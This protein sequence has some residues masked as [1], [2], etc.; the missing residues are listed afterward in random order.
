MCYKLQHG[1]CSFGIQANFHLGLPITWCS[2]KMSFSRT[3]HKAEFASPEP[4]LLG[5]FMSYAGCFHPYHNP[6]F[7]AHLN[8]SFMYIYAKASY[9][10]YW[11]AS[12]SEFSLSWKHIERTTG[13]QWKWVIRAFSSFFCSD[14]L[15]R[16]HISQ[17]N[18]ADWKKLSWNRG[19]SVLG[20]LEDIFYSHFNYES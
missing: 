2:F 7:I 9:K 12:A 5:I 6:L 1:D 10:S 16:L 4:Q 14:L 20:F 8:L 18:G 15:E 17:K 19:I 11:S 3:A 13:G